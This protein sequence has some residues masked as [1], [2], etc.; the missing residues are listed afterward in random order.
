M[1]QVPLSL[2]PQRGAT[3]ASFRAGSNAALLSHLHSACPPQAAIYLWGPTGCGKTHLLQAVAH[4][5]HVAGF[6][7]GHFRGQGGDDLEYDPAWAVVILDDVHTLDAQAQHAAF[8]WLVQAQSHGAT[9]L[10]AGVCPPIDLPL[11]ED[12]RSRLAWGHVFAVEPLDEAQTRSVLRQ[13]ADRRGIFLSDEVM[14]Y[15]MH[16]LERNLS[17]LMRLLDRLDEFA[18][19]QHRAVTV[20]LLRQMLSEEVGV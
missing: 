14:D 17:F 15:L 12:L 8:A 7:V 2:A 11:R 20:P 5:C 4:G 10:A 6:Q 1:R 16:R 19:S 18:L 13:E 9:W 3:L